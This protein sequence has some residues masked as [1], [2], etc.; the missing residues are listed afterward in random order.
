M[1]IP[2][3]AQKAPYFI[4]VEVGKTYYW[5][6]CGLSRKQPLCD[7]SHKS[8]NLAPLAYV[9]METKRVAMCGC[10]YSATKPLCDGSHNRL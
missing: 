4:D 8:T 5:C 9:A 2:A 1:T 7:G 10:K 3:V 6:R